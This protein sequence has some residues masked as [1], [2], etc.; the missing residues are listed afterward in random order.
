M[1][2]LKIQHIYF[3]LLKPPS[4]TSIPCYQQS[5]CMFRIYIEIKFDQ[6]LN[7]FTGLYQIYRQSIHANYKG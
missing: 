3:F 2:C 6:T 1:K 5:K 4:I 7:T